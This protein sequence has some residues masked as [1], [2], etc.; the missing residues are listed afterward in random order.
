MATSLKGDMFVPEVAAAVASA[1]FINELAVGFP[2]SPMVRIL[3]EV[4]EFQD[5]GDLIKFPRWN[6][7][8]EMTDQVEDTA[9]TPEKLDTSVDSAPLVG[10][11]KAAELTDWATLTSGGDPSTE[12][13]RQLA[14]IAARYVDTK[15]IDRAN[16]TE[17]VADQSGGT[18]VATHDTFVDAIFNN[19]GDRA[20]VDIGGL[21]VTPSSAKNLLKSNEFKSVDF[22]GV[23]TADPNG[24]RAIGMLRNFPVFVSGRLADGGS[25]GD[26]TNLIFK[27]GAMGLRFK[28][29]LMV[30]T[31]RDVL[32][33]NDVIV[34][35]VW[36]AVHQLFAEP[37]TVIKWI[38]DN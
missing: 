38:T 35:R 32:K 19:W 5:Q 29:D 6:A 12:V 26:S 16:A 13:G 27:R 21:V 14:T 23:A 34:G 25:S 20:Q 4:P 33:G 3:N 15:L 36:I 1:E 2:A 18:A 9:L 24:V 31:D 17:L 10:G 28:R 11:G 30:E 8:G 37:R 22:A 7:L